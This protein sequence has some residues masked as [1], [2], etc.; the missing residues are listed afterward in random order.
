M[1]LD[2]IHSVLSRSVG[3]ENIGMISEY[4]RFRPKIRETGNR[5]ADA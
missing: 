1:N 5:D 3:D 4:G 2:K